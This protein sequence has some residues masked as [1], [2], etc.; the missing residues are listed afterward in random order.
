MPVY[1]RCSALTQKR[2]PKNILSM[3]VDITFSVL[4]FQIS[5]G[6]LLLKIKALSLYISTK[7][8]LRQTFLIIKLT[9]FEVLYDIFKIMDTFLFVLFF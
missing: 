2:V 5:T 7:N 1:L 6:T 3:T 9:C 8:K 4:M